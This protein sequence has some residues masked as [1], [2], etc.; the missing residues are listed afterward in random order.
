MICPDCGLKVGGFVHNI[1]SHSAFVCPECLSKAKPE[2]I[3]GW[4]IAPRW[5]GV[6]RGRGVFA[7]DDLASGVT[8]ERCWVM[9]LSEEESLQSLSMPI[10]NRYLFP[11]FNGRRCITSGHGLLYNFDR[12]DSTVRVPNTICV[13]REGLSAIEFRTNRIVR[14]G[15][16]LTWDYS[17]AVSKKS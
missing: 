2:P 10:V 15:E 4:P 14:S 8:V 9:P 13:L 6:D 1:E 11:W 17:R 3:G 16:E 12:F 7:R 5:I